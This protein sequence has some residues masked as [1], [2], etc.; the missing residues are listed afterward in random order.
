MSAHIIA[1][2]RLFVPV[3]IYY[4]HCMFTS[5]AGWSGGLLSSVSLSSAF[6]SRSAGN[7]ESDRGT[8]RDKKQGTKKPKAW[9]TVTARVAFYHKIDPHILNDLMT[10]VS[11]C[12]NI[13]KQMSLIVCMQKH[14]I[15]LKKYG[16]KKKGISKTTEKMYK[17][18]TGTSVT[19]PQ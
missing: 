11:L 7:R 2:I 18:A 1:E 3:I 10:F 5:S 9:E 17:D 16:L 15:F 8:K 12:K 14:F 19:Q 6:D 13:G 4:V